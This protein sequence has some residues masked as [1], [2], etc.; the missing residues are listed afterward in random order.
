MRVLVLGG[1]GFIGPHTIRK[2]AADGHQVTVFHR[3]KKHAELVERIFMSDRDLPATIIRIPMTYGEGD[4]AHRMFSYLKRMDDG[5]KVIPLEQS[6]ARVRLPLG[7]VQDVGAA[8]ALAVTNDRAAG[9]IYNVA[10]PDVRSTAAWVR[11]IGEAIGWKGRVVEVADGSLP[12]P[13]SA[14]NLKQ[15]VIPDTTRIR[16]ELG[17]REIVPRNE[18]IRRTVEWERAHPPEPFPAALFDYEAEDR[19][20]AAKGPT[21][22]S[23]AS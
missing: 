16:Q 18:A 22:T 4:Y 19:V 5:R 11:E 14:Y 10:E 17:Y 1:T 3:G 2:L 6:A 12:G 21:A 13:W 23:G 9:R 7:Y 8:I 15:H 20:L